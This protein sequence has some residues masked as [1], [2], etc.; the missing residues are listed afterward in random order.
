[1]VLCSI[2]HG[3]IE[4]CQWAMQGICVKSCTQRQRKQAMC[5]DAAWG[6]SGPA[7]WVDG[8]SMRL[9]P[10]PG[11]PCSVQPALPSNG[12]AVQWSMRPASVPSNVPM[13][14]S[15]QPAPASNVTSMQP[16]AVPSNIPMQWSM[17]PAPASNVTWAA[18]PAPWSLN[19]HHLLH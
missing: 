4:V 2:I 11:M 19:P 1:M 9:G 14:W 13:Q 18:Q 6:S 12:G 3:D 17:Q 16:A 8:R 15:M 7:Y 10:Q 5:S